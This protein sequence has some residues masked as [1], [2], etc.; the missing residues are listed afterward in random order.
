VL[1]SSWWL[2]RQGRV[3][4]SDTC[5]AVVQCLVAQ[6]TLVYH[7]CYLMMGSCGPW[8]L[9]PGVVLQVF[10]VWDGTWETCMP[11]HTVLLHDLSILSLCTCSPL[12]CVAACIYQCVHM[13]ANA[14]NFAFVP[15]QQRILYINVLSVSGLECEP[16]CPHAVH[17]RSLAKWSMQQHG[18]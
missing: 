8:H 7:F 6:D 13:Q 5:P 16:F 12:S 17:L 1:T 10:P 11:V 18:Y 15:P 14:I 9:V 3:Y 4:R 2:R